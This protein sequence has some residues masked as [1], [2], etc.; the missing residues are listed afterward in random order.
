MSCR[1][2]QRQIQEM[3]QLPHW[4]AWCIRLTFGGHESDNRRLGRH[5]QPVGKSSTPK[6]SAF[7][8]RTTTTLYAARSYR[9]Q[10]LLGFPDGLELAISS[11]AALRW[12]IQC[13]PD[14]YT[15]TCAA[16][17]LKRSHESLT[18]HQATLPQL[19]SP[20]FF[21]S[22]TTWTTPSSFSS[23]NLRVSS[24]KNVGPR[25]CIYRN[26]R[27]LSRGCRPRRPHRLPRSQS[28]LT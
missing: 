25:V 2:I 3:R 12:T 6:N 14:A 18:T 17:C 7:F 22:Q 19:S 4:F 13:L 10:S 27:L 1:R 15:C 24:K 20:T 23:T 9:L 5:R 11:V 16:E 28:A 26:I 21:Y 8:W